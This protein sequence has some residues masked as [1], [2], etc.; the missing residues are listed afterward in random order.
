MGFHFHEVGRPRSC[1]N[2]RFSVY[3][4]CEDE[5]YDTKLLRASLSIMSKT[6]KYTKIPSIGDGYCMVAQT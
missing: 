6:L 3:P 5:R 2:N 4:A 1:K